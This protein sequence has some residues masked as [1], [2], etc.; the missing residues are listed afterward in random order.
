MRAW[1]AALDLETG[2][3]WTVR[4]VAAVLGWA[5]DR[6]AVPTLVALLEQLPSEGGFD[7]ALKYDDLIGD[8]AVC[9]RRIGDPAGAAPLVRFASATSARMR[10]ARSESGFAVGVLAPALGGEPLLA[11]MLDLARSINDSDEDAL[12]LAAYG[13]VGRAQPVS[14]HPRLAAA[15]AATEPMA[16]SYVEVKLAQAIALALLGAPPSGDAGVAALMTTAF[17]APGWKL[18]YTVR[19][20][21]WA[22]E[23]YRIIPAVAPELVERSLDIDD[24]VYADEVVATLGA[25]ARQHAPRAVSYFDADRAGDDALIGWLRDPALRG[26]HLVALLLGRRKAAAARSAL[27]EAADHIA[28]AAPRDEGTDLLEPV[29][30]LLREVVRALRCLPPAPSTIAVLARLL[31]HPNRDV[32][33]PVLRDPPSDPSLIPAMREIA[34]AGWGWQGSTAEEWL[35]EHGKQRQAD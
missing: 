28:Q 3:D 24:E 6:A 7:T 18:E 8:L 10:H 1:L 15:L 35:A 20:R 11:G 30:R 26:R 2:L 9:L 25:A 33:A 14:E 23:M 32:K 19:R 31:A 16:A 13:L 29:E 21:R 27:E 5:R 4:Q 17:T 12:A 22:L 34:K